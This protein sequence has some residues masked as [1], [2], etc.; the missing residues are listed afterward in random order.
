MTTAVTTEQLLE[1][2][3]QVL[4]Y[5]ASREGEEGAA[6]RLVLAGAEPFRTDGPYLI[7]YETCQ[8][9]S[10]NP[11][12]VPAGLCVCGHPYNRHF[13]SYDDDAP[14]GCKYCYCDE[15]VCEAV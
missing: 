7:R 15:F 6:A 9:R 12:Y 5:Y 4:L 10:I 2:Y 8:V 11:D 3:R 13:D 1:Q 14:V